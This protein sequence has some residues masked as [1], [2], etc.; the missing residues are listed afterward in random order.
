MAYNTDSKVIGTLRANG[1]LLANIVPNSGIIGGS[2]SVVQL[3]AWNW[4][5]AVVVPDNA[6]HM[7]W[8]GIYSYNY[9]KGT[10]EISSTYNQELLMINNFMAEAKAYCAVATHKEKNLKFEAIKLLKPAQR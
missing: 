7:Y 1:I 10:Y 4:E 2:S 9:Q 3:D 8:P 6:M 5:D